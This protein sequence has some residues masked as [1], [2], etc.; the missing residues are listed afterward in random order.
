MEK[1]LA[2]LRHEVYTLLSRF[3]FWFGVLGVPIISFLV[4]S[5]I[6]MINRSQ[7]ADNKQSNP[8]ANVGQLFAA[9]QE[10]RP[11][12][13]VDP[14]GLIKKYP[15][16]MNGD[17][18]RYADQAAARR[19]LDAEKISAFYVIPP[20]YIQ[21]G[22][23]FVYTPEFN[24]VSTEGR[25]NGLQAL[26][27]YNL[28]SGD[29]QL[30]QAISKPVV[31]IEEINLSPQTP[32]NQRDRNNELTFL[33]PYGVMMLFFITIMGSSTML[34]NSVAKEKE[35]RM[36][37]VLMISATPHQILLGKIIGLGLVGLLQVVIWASSAVLLMRLGGETFNLPPA[38]QLPPSIIAWGV[39][40]FLLGYLVYAA[41]MAGLGALVPNLREASQA[42]F[43]IM[44]P[45]MVPLFLLSALITAP[46]GVLAVALSLFPFTASTT[47]MLRLSSTDV[48]LWQLL[49][50]IGL[51]IATGWF[52][53]RAVAGIFRAQTILSGE[54]F[55]LK[56]FFLALIG[57]L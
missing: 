42:T 35:N 28:L 37:E 10:N 31:D 46:N 17:F 24:L 26:I 8:M 53:I 14:A 18:H 12:G 36:M 51:L 2:I 3:S 9:P 1:T 40:F 6:G 48:P 15:V 49:L 50:A 20:D 25:S 39:V 27:T 13:F 45:M 19:D 32:A 29:E 41:L 22:K 55:H 43:V 52:V 54:P 11:Q 4:I 16:H 7:G 44:L 30:T 56:R 34:L 23:L 57:K 33:L 47:M 38:F 5:G 21:T